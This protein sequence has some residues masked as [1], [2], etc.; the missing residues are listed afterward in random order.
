[1]VFFLV[2]WLVFCLS[3]VVPRANVNAQVVSTEM[4]GG[5]LAVL[6]S[7]SSRDGVSMRV[8]F[9]NV[10]A[11]VLPTPS[12]RAQ[13][14]DEDPVLGNL[15]YHRA[16]VAVRRGR[17]SEV[18]ALLE[19]L[20]A[21]DDFDVDYRLE[22]RAYPLPNV[23]EGTEARRLYVLDTVLPSIFPSA[24]SAVLTCGEMTESRPNW[25]REGRICFNRGSI[26]VVEPFLR[27]ED[28][29]PD[30]GPL[31]V[32]VGSWA[33]RVVI[34]GRTVGPP[35]TY[36]E[37]LTPFGR[38]RY[39]DADSVVIES[40]QDEA[41][42]LLA[43]AVVTDDV[44]A[45]NI[46]LNSGADV[47]AVSTSGRTSMHLAAE[48]NALRAADRL[49][50]AGASLGTTAAE[51]QTPLHIAS[52]HGFHEMI[53]LLTAA[54][55]SLD[56]PQS[57][58][59]TPLLLAVDGAHVSAVEAL[60]RAGADVD[61]ATPE[62]YSPL[63]A[64]ASAISRG[65]FSDARIEVLQVLLSAGAV[66]DQR[67]PEG[68]TALHYAAQSADAQ[69]ADLL[70]DAGAAVDAAID[71]GSTALM[72]AAEMGHR[73]TLGVLADGGA[74]VEATDQEG[75]T[76]LMRAA[77]ANTAGAFED[78]LRRGARKRAQNNAG[79]T[80]AAIAKAN[81]S[82]QVRSV[83]EHIK[84]VQFTVVKLGANLARLNDPQ[85]ASS[86]GGELGVALALKV[87]SRLHAQVDF[88]T[89]V[90]VTDPG[91]DGPVPFGAPGDF[92]YFL[93]TLEVKPQL[94]VALTNPY[95]GHLYA[96][97]GVS[98]GS[99]IEAELRDYSG[100]TGEQ[101]VTD[102]SDQ[103]YTAFSVGLGYQA[104][105]TRTVA[106]LEL[107]YSRTGS[108]VVD[109]FEGAIDTFGFSLGFGL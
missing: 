105:F 30:D 34:D 17:A 32:F 87:M 88:G 33:Q 57:D 65:T 103:S 79:Y 59:R 42:T 1:M 27:F 75:N 9:V 106:T 29:V 43:A 20:R 91:E 63:M 37:V 56:A 97:A 10:P 74:S 72:M 19:I 2:L 31:P 77:S 86:I 50:R 92:Y 46:V 45:M 22:R 60:I 108:V 66:V 99:L 70:L 4:S 83:L 81:R 6:S 41:H 55:A 71:D 58:G 18:S 35:T 47:D 90:R 49:V 98:F 96:L 69:V 26:R 8:E 5:Q 38:I 21:R 23:A 62:G 64:A 28:N 102:N 16:E 109:R 14:I 95:R 25:I 54:G 53:D 107:T 61:L 48:H 15:L 84:P 36:L 104:A 44:E 101:V 93:S 80:S 39:N 12:Q 11:L 7:E 68:R 100:Q 13:R 52:M 51:G 82:N 78:L 73:K 24:S 67:G 40:D 94:R 89:Q 85:H 3:T 76:A